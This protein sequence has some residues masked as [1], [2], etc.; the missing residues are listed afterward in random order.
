V[1]VNKALIDPICAKITSYVRYYKRKVMYHSDL[2]ALGSGTLLVLIRKL[3]DRLLL[4]VV[5]QSTQT[6]I[7]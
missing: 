2:E 7:L 5:L 1:E 3:S 4:H 6:N